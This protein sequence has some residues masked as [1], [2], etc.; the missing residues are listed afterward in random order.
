MKKHVYQLG[1][2]FFLFGFSSCVV[3]ERYVVRERPAEVYYARP[4]QP[5][6]E[7]IWITGDWVWSSGG[8]R[9]RE[10]HWERRRS[11]VR[12]QEGHW[13]QTRNGWKWIPGHWQNF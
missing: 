10:G 9:W 8:Y 5:S 12:W 4:P 2:L 3:H 11:G 13:Q 6:P 7:H 1:L